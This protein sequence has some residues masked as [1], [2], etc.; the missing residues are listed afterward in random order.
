[1]LCTID[2]SGVTDRGRRRS[3]HQINYSLCCHTLKKANMILSSF[4]SKSCLSLWKQLQSWLHL[5]LETWIQCAKGWPLQIYVPMRMLYIFF[6]PQTS[7]LM[8]HLWR[9]MNRISF[10][11]LWSECDYMLCQR[12]L[13]PPY[14]PIFPPVSCKNSL[15][16]SS[17][18]TLST[19]QHL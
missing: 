17:F 9:S 13:L 10:D 19:S 14:L 18:S 5:R 4:Q 6:H 3:G 12:I 15:W 2:L 1:M 8:L 7:I 11:P 16:G